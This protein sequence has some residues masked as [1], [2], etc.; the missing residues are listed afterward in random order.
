M[1]TVTVNTSKVEA[2]LGANGIPNAV[3]RNLRAVVPDLTRMLAAAVDNNLNTGLKSRNR[4]VVKQQMVENGNKLVGRVTVI[5]TR[6]PLLLPMW[7]E[8]GT[9]AHEIAAKNASA[10]Y[11]FWGRLGRF[12]S[13]KKVWHPG[14]PG[15]AY[16]QNAFESLEDEVRTQLNFAVYQ[17]TKLR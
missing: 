17:G 14:F 12:V 3:R 15:I 7:L 11:F 9:Q 1:I 6:E 4:L 2:L 5:S 16:M 13:F 10:L 8:K